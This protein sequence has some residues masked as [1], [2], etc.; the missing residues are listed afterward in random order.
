MRRLILV[1]LTFFLV[2]AA[3]PLL[4]EPA[5][6]Q[7]SSSPA[8]R[9]A[10]VLRFFQKITVE[11]YQQHGRH[12]PRWDDDARTTLEALARVL[13][14]EFCPDGDEYDVFYTAGKRALDSG[15]TDPLI[16]LAVGRGYVFFSRKYDDVA[17]LHTESAKR[18]GES[19]YHP[20]LKCVSALRGAVL[21]G[22]FKGDARVA[23]REGRRMI[24]TAMEALPK[25]LADPDVPAEQ[26]LIVMDQ[27]GDASAIVER[28]RAV[29]FNN[30]FAILEQSPVSRSLVLT[31]KA[32]FLLGYAQDA[33]PDTG[34]DVQA[35]AEAEK[36][37]KDRLDQAAAAGEQAW[38]LDNT[39]VYAAEA[40][41]RIEAARGNLAEARDTWLSRAVAADPESYDAHLLEL[42]YLA[43]AYQSNVPAMIEF[44]RRCLAGAAWESGVPMVLIEAHLRGSRYSQGQEPGPVQQ[45]YFASSPEVWK[46]I[47]A[48]YEPYLQRFPNSLYHRS[49]YAQLACWCGQWA[50][51]DRQFK[52]MGD[53]FS[54]SWF[55][56]KEAYLRQ[57]AELAKHIGARP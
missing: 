46:D 34:A 30:A 42:T 13:A 55:R 17:P 12:D 6:T 14:S 5:T 50:D 52:A 11:D 23:R 19:V 21:R 18:I 2:L 3:G 27:F 31:A 29:V 47:R 38:R 16:L 57:R 56:T 45:S 53:R 40:M 51:A 39:N 32:Q 10:A 37:C 25:M 44:G 7:S 15:C 20:L 9:R 36:L 28:D 8:D 22:K 35:S 48:V 4:A 33:E 1:A 26:V 54:L 49:R 41:M 24:D 43:P